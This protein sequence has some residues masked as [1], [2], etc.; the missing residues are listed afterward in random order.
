[1]NKSE[2]EKKTGTVQIYTQEKHK[3]CV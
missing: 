1:M 2:D 3:H